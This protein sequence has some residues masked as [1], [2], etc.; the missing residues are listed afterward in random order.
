M[1]ITSGDT[2]GLSPS[3]NLQYLILGTWRISAYLIWQVIL[4]GCSRWYLYRT[5]FRIHELLAKTFPHI[6]LRRRHYGFEIF[7]VLAFDIICVLMAQSLAH[8]QFTSGVLAG[9]LSLLMV[10]QIDRESIMQRGFHG[11]AVDFT[12][13]QVSRSLIWEFSYSFLAIPVMYILVLGSGFPCAL[14]YAARVAIF[15]DNSSRTLAWLGGWASTGNSSPNE[16]REAMTLAGALLDLV[17]PN[18]FTVAFYNEY[19]P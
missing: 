4:A 17:H 15:C 6:A 11:W 13:R 10:R 14:V 8:W 9:C 12:S 5:V 16:L 7:S 1:G 3:F 2:F 18:I 19:C